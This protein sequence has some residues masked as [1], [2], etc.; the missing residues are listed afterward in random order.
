MKFK[1]GDVVKYFNDKFFKGIVTG[2][3]GD[4]IYVKWNTTEPPVPHWES[5]LRLV[6]DPSE[7]LK[8]IL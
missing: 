5:D 7:I 3:A 4:N 2:F 8:E 1:E 6:I